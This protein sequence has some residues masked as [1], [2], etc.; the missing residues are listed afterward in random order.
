MA[1][2]TWPVVSC[3][4]SPGWRWYQRATI[5][6]PLVGGLLLLAAAAVAHNSTSI[7]LLAFGG[8]YVCMGAGALWYSRHVAGALHLENGQVT[9]VFPARERRIPAGDVLSFRRGR[10]DLSRVRPML[11]RTS[12]HGTIKVSARLV[13]LFDFLY[14]LRQINPDVVIRDL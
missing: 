12:T 2:H 9:F 3:T 1:P 11:V 4:T 6:F 5:G 10:M 8:A 14:R 7:V 13:G